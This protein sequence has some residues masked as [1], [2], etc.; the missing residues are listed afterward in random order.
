[1]FH[2]LLTELGASEAHLRQHRPRGQ[3][4]RVP[5]RA[6]AKRRGYL[7]IP[8]SAGPRPS[9]HDVPVLADAFAL[10]ALS[11]PAFPMPRA[12]GCPFGQPPGL[13]A[14]QA[15]KPLSK[16]RLW[17]GKTAW[18]ALR[19]EYHQRLLGDP[20][21]SADA[22]T[23]GW[24]PLPRIPLSAR[25]GRRPSSLWPTASTTGS[26]ECWPRAGRPPGLAGR[27]RCAD[28]PGLPLC[29]LVIVRCRASFGTG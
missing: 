5:H 15:A 8:D 4:A 24:P 7:S 6:P 17:N 1:M 3:G 21:L 11:R 20:R 27:R 22:T 9:Q 16:V 23:P 13:R 10:L 12:P 19:H 25:R 14:L 28:G 2:T 26:A 18:L 29:W